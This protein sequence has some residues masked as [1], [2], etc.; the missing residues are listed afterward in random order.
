V[1]NPQQIFEKKSTLFSVLVAIIVG[2][3]AIPIIL[4]NIFHGFHTFHILLHVGGIVLAAFLTVLGVI[5]YTRLRTKKLLLSS[6]GFGVLIT[7]EFVTLIDVTWPFTYAIGNVSLEEIN[8]LLMI[9][10]L[11]FLA[12][13]VFRND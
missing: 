6:L 12:I 7:A 9:T 4:P 5:A 2:L 3:L 1:F 10:T 13:G 8:H 11:G